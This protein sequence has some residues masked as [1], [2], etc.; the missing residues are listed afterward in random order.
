MIYT[1][2]TVK[3]SVEFEGLGLHGGEPVRVLVHPGEDGI[4]F[5]TASGR[6][7]AVA[8]NVT[9]TTRCT[10]LG[11]VSTIEH[12]MSALAG[13]EVTDAEV[14]VRGG[15][16]PAMDGS[17]QGF[18]EGIHSVGLAPVG[19]AE[20]RTPFKRVFLQEDGIKIAV[21]K[22]E[23]HWQYTYD[24]GERWPGQQTFESFNVALEYRKAIA[25]ARTFA[26]AEEIPAILQLGLAKGLD[27]DTALILGIEGYKNDPRFEDEPA[28]HKLL[29]LIGDL[30][31]TGIPIRFLNVSAERSGHA[32]NVR[33]A[34]LVRQSLASGAE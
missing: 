16:M 15:E 21:G 24:L 6:W 19:E 8:E 9:D 22:G 3:D 27:Q 11:E 23:G 31:L 10:R 1:R 12:L 28:R 4:A 18:A 2:L 25:P 32:S 33:A 20:V 14:E 7:A 5:R 29:D 30:Y 34:A 26:L 13:L 17:S